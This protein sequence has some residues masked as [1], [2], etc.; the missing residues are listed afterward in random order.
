[1]K[2]FLKTTR[3]VVRWSY[4]VQA[5]IIHSSKLTLVQRETQVVAIAEL[6]IWKVAKSKDYPEGTKY[7][8]FFVLK[9]TGE[10]LVGFDNHKP[11]GHHK[12]QN[13]LESNYDFQNMNKLTDDFWDEVNKRGF[14]L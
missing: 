2:K 4:M 10:I 13:G 5:T 1:M 7:S 9:D 12:H 14:I 3:Y 8:L 11:K 6:K